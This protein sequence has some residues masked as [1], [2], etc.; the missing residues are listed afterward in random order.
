MNQLM[1][2]ACSDWNTPFCA[3]TQ[4]DATQA[5]EQGDVIFLPDLTFSLH[6]AELPL[7]SPAHVHPKRKNISFNPI[8]HQ[9]GGTTSTGAMKDQLAQL[10][11]RYSE[12]SS[13][14][15]TQLF[16]D[17]KTCLKLGRTSFRP[18]EIA[19]RAASPKKDD[20][21]LHVDAFPS[22]PLRDR[23]ILRVF[24]N[25]NPHQQPRVW[26][27]GEAF[28]TVAARF[29]AEIPAPKP[30]HH[31][32][33][34][35]LKITKE[36]R[37]AYDHYMLQIHDRMKLNQDY[38]KKVAKTRLELPAQSTWI[39]YTDVVS[40]AALSGQHVLE[41]TFYLPFQAMANENHAPQRILEEYLKKPL[42]DG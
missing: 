7:L 41:Q 14:L 35:R 19:N 40:H 2:Y 30:W 13:R 16:P 10:L 26:H 42:Q 15:V 6:D 33:L 11:L 21:R 8:T 31:W 4:E 32:L 23:R 20:T 25:I 37:T 36:R 39:V 29:L 27:L 9:L 22:T 24:T 1:R 17:Y 18:V 3:A 38:Q 28:C 34:H 5:L 12:V